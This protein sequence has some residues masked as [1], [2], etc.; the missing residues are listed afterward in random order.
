MTQYA[1]FDPNAS[2]PT[3]VI[4]WYDTDFAT[5]SMLPPTVET[6]PA[7]FLVMTQ[8]QWDAHMV[9]PSG[10]AVENGQTLVDYVAPAPV[11]TLE[12]QADRAL[13][14]G[15]AITLSGSITL[16]ATVFPVDPSAT[17]KIGAVVTTIMATQAFP[18]GITSFPMKDSSGAW[19][20]FTLAQY[21]TVAGA[22]SAYVAA[23]NLITDG[24]PL[25]AVA[26]PSPSV[27][28]TV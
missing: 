11:L 8:D 2:S 27:S 10:W 24:N 7:G 25:N 19:H 9:N 17:V 1:Q 12:Q 21:T 26:L 16:A 22:I 4:G 28:L 3:P 23:L 15:L 13:Y 5:Y 6:A 14:Q 18:G 20:T